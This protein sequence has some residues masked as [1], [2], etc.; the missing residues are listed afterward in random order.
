MDQGF[1]LLGRGIVQDLEL[2]MQGSGIIKLGAGSR[3][4]G[5]G[6]SSLQFKVQGRSLGVDSRVA[7][8]T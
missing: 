1:K 4:R 3:R 2:E 8:A 5:F 6:A 7:G